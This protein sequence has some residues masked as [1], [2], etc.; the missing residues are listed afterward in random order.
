MWCGQRQT[1]RSEDL[2]E[3]IST[4][5]RI[6]QFEENQVTEKLK[7]MNAETL[8][9]LKRAQFNLMVHSKVL[10]YKTSVNAKLL[11]LKICLRNNQKQRPHEQLSPVFSDFTERLVFLFAG[12]KIGDLE[13]LM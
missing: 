10:I 8:E 9:D 5:S 13:K 12:N 7:I 6:Y 2:K 1:S 3:Y 4:E 11:Q